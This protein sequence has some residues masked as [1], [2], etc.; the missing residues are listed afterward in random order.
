MTVTVLIHVTESYWER[1]DCLIVT[2]CTLLLFIVYT[3]TDIVYCLDYCSPCIRLLLTVLLYRY[4]HCIVP[5][6]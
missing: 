1:K 3:V 2:P 4:C 6:F 5:V